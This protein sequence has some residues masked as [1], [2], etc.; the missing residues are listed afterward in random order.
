MTTP[1]QPHR[2]GGCDCGAV[3]FEVSGPLPGITVCHCKQCRRRTGYLWGS[4]KV[5]D[6]QF[7]FTYGADEVQWYA[8]SDWAR[9]GFCRCCG[10]QLFYRVTGDGDDHAAIT[11]GAFDEPNDLHLAKHIFVKDKADYIE[12]GDE[13]PQIDRY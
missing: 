9:R 1:S 13:A 2:S 6:V 3:R 12:I 4:V 11:A 5:P 8:S 10:S 7:R